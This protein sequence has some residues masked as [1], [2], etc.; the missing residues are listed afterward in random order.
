MP[1]PPIAVVSL[2]WLDDYAWY[3][4]IQFLSYAPYENTMRNTAIIITVLHNKEV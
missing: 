4:S 1:L 3:V 2:S